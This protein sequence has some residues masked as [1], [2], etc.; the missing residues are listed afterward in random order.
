MKKALLGS[1]LCF[2]V[3]VAAAGAFF[4]ADHSNLVLS[5]R[6]VIVK[7]PS[8]A[9]TPWVWQDPSLKTIASNL[10]DYPYGVFFC[11]YG[12]YVTGLTNVLQ[13]VPEYWEAAPFT[14]SANMTIKEV[15]ADVE[16]NQG[17][18]T[19]AIV[20]SVYDDANGLPGKALES[21][22][23]KNLGHNGS[24]CT[25][26]V[27]KSKSGIAVTQGTQYWVVAS[28]NSKD[29]TT[30]STWDANTTDMRLHPVAYYCDDSKQ[31]SCNGNSGKWTASQTIVPG[32]AVLGE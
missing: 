5:G 9:I 31:G 24:C 10:S 23:V 16:W 32:F 30:F 14:P 7:H 27:G 1:L 4:A 3:L 11:C 6:E 12:Y 15:E 13:V 20:L 8:G 2:I 21:W 25:L 29:A 26:A 28:T 17:E 18:G 19:D 22:Y